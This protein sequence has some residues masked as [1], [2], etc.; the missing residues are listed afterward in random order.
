M[1]RALDISTSGLVAQRIRLNAISGNLA[2]MSSVRNER[3]EV[4]P[5]QERFVVF[6]PDEEV[7]S[8]D[9]AV[10]VKVSQVRTETVEPKYRYQPGHPLAIREGKW[11]GYV[12]YPNMDMMTQF[13]DALIAT[14]AYEAN[15]GVMEV[16][17]NLGEQ[18]MR[19]IG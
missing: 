16:T 12:A 5:Y 2:N 13:V 9:G 17:K 3:G 4:Q 19:I 14:R 10:G 15:L 1:L 6:Q 7:R 18:S 8:A 11:K